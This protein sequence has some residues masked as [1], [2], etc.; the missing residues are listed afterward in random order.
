M[1]FKTGCPDSSRD[2]DQARNEGAGVLAV[3]EQVYWI[4]RGEL[5][6]LPQENHDGAVLETE[7]LQRRGFIKIVHNKDGTTIKWDLFAANWAAIYFAIDFIT[8]LRGPYHLHY[9]LAGWFQETYDDVEVARDRIDIILGKSDVRLSTRTFVQEAD[10][11]RTD[12]P[13]TLKAALTERKIAPE[14]S[15]DCIYDPLTGRFLV[16]RVGAK[17]TIAQL[18]GMS[19]VSYPCLTGHSYDQMVSR[20][21]PKVLKSGDAHYDHVYAAMTA[22]D[23]TIVWI[24][25]QRV[26]LPKRFGHRK[27]G[28]AILTERT[29]VDISVL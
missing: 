12:I 18:W 28:V 8:S 9:F 29:K 23:G 19:P 21:Y 26:V 20:A 27:R 17:S 4:A 10:P 25:Y 2:G 24:P 11:K 16:D 14:Y 13:S 7:L 6:T 5:A 3:D 22:P 15:V 1:E